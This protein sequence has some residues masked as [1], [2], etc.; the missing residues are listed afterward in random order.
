MP[1][2]VKAG[3]VSS[4]GQNSRG[5]RQADTVQNVLNVFNGNHLP[6]MGFLEACS[7]HSD[8]SADVYFER[9]KEEALG[10]SLCFV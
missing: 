3:R 1:P 4:G 6:S 9:A 8:V 5:S 2:G 7:R 10:V